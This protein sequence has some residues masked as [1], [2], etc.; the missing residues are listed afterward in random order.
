MSSMRNEKRIRVFALENRMQVLADLEMR[1]GKD[2]NGKLP[3]GD[4]AFVKISK[5]DER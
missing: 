4:S 1:L 3:L 5:I 2:L